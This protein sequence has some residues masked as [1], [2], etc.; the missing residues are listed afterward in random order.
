ME[1][2]FERRLS[3]STSSYSPVYLFPSNFGLSFESKDQGRFLLKR[4]RTSPSNR[5]KLI[6]LSFT[7]WI[8]STNQ[9][10]IIIQV[11]NRRNNEAFQLTHMFHFTSQRPRDYTRFFHNYR[12]LFFHYPYGKTLFELFVSPYSIHHIHDPWIPPS[13]SPGFRIPVLPL[14][15]SHSPYLGCVGVR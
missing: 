13:I 2:F 7:T 11:C 14:Y 15:L 8:P 3:H 10:R 5:R 1:M 9:N 6:C 4:P 12:Y